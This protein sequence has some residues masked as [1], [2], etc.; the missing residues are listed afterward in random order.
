[1]HQKQQQQRKIRKRNKKA[2]ELQGVFHL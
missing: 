1:M 2:D